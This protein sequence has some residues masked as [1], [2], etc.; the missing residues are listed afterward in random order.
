MGVYLPANLRPD[1]FRASRG[2]NRLRGVKV[3]IE[4]G[5]ILWIGPF[6]CTW[7]L[8]LGQVFQNV[9]GGTCPYNL[10]SASIR[11]G[12]GGDRVEVLE[13]VE[14]EGEVEPVVEI[15]VEEVEGRRKVVMVVVVM[16]PNRAAAVVPS[17]SDLR[18]AAEGCSLEQPPPSRSR[19]RPFEGAPP[20]LGH[21]ASLSPTL[22]IACSV[23]ALKVPSSF[24]SSSNHG[25]SILR[26]EGT[27]EPLWRSQGAAA[28]TINSTAYDIVFCDLI[29]TRE[30]PQWSKSCKGKGPGYLGWVLVT[31]C[32]PD[33][34]TTSPTHYPILQRIS[35]NSDT[36]SSFPQIPYSSNYLLIP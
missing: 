2:R 18:R 27:P 21:S 36:G 23:E 24:Q 9:S 11:V 12:R 22:P 29:G 13:E 3:G 28:Q 1:F 25:G 16:P 30:K 5:L 34:K 31:V 7:A 6:V 19:R 32:V 14:G 33:A 35:P 17:T 8:S 20:L 15:R 10:Y 26:R 4:R